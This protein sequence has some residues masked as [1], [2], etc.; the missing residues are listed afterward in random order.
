MKA[1]FL[2]AFLLMNFA[3]TDR[4]D[5]GKVV[6]EFN[7]GFNKDNDYTTLSRINGAKLYR[8]DIESKPSLKEK[9]K[10]NSVPTVI[11][12]NDGQERYRWEAGIDMRLH[13]HYTEIQEVITRY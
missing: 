4:I 11:Y 3:V 9:Y 6:I 1:L 8:I 10:I 13:V 7:A 5:N 12:F 2:S